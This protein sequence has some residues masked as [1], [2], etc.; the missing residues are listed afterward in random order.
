MWGRVFIC[1][2]SLLGLPQIASFSGTPAALF[3]FG[4]C[5]FKSFKLRLSQPTVT[6][7]SAA[8]ALGSGRRHG[9]QGPGASSLQMKTQGLFAGLSSRA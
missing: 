4:V 7:H 6:G 1:K 2:S 8:Q 5:V 9:V 3:M